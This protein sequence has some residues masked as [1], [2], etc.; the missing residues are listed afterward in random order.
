M[1]HLGLSVVGYNAARS[2]VWQWWRRSGEEVTVPV[3]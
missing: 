1:L 2:F 3:S